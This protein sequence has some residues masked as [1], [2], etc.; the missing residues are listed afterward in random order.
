MS[1][2]IIVLQREEPPT[3]E[4]CT[5]KTRPETETVSRFVDTKLM[6]FLNFQSLPRLASTEVTHDVAMCVQGDL[7]FE[8]FLSQGNK[9]Q[10]FGLQSA[11]DH[12]LT[13]AARHVHGQ[14]DRGRP[15]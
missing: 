10:P 13:I 2:L 7:E 14:S 8:V 11:L 5:N 3:D 12:L 15:T 9:S 1:S 4:V 6:V